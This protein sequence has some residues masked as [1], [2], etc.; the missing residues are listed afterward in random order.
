MYFHK[1]TIFQNGLIHFEN[2]GCSPKRYAAVLV[3]PL[4]KN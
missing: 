1:F 3:R 4:Y 2:P